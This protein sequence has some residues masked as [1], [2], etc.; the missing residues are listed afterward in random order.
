ML[1]LLAGRITIMTAE[2]DSL[3]SPRG[4]KDRGSGEG[5]IKV[6]QESSGYDAMLTAGPRVMARR[7]CV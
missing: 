2:P 6:R 4:R 7:G 3:G 1:L 5:F